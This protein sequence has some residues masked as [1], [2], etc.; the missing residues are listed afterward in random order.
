MLSIIINFYVSFVIL[1]FHYVYI[2][3]FC[4]IN[5]ILYYILTK[6]TIS[7]ANWI[8]DA[9]TTSRYRESHTKG[10]IDNVLN[11]QEVA[12]YVNVS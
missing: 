10:I 1:S 9:E 12:P 2:M 8:I 3:L 6:S 7:C 5:I 4:Q 11:Y